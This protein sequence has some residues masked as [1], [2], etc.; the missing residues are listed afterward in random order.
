MGHAER[1]AQ[2]SPL[3]LSASPGDVRFTRYYVDTVGWIIEGYVDDLGAM[4]TQDGMCCVCVGSA[5]ARLISNSET[6]FN[7][8]SSPQHLIG[9][10][11]L[12][13]FLSPLGITILMFF[14][15]RWSTDHGVPPQS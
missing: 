14:L 15:L 7:A 6:I 13:C 4:Y 9:D 1:S 10:S 11:V 5:A 2:W 12:L 8:D 3:G